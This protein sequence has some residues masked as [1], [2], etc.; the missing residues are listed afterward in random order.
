[1]SMI[2]FSENKKH[3]QTKIFFCWHYIV[4]NYF[5]TSAIISLLWFLLATIITV[6]I[7]C[8]DCLSQLVMS[9][10][11]SLVN[12]V[13][14][15]TVGLSFRQRQNA[16]WFYSL[17]VRFGHVSQSSTAAPTAGII[18]SHRPPDTISPVL[19][20]SVT[21]WRFTG[22]RPVGITQ[23][24]FI[25]LMYPTCLRSLWEWDRERVTRFKRFIVL[26]VNRQSDE[27]RCTLTL[28]DYSLLTINFFFII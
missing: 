4:Q 10:C 26:S 22:T 11:S 9:F 16:V 18:Y 6:K 24:H 17:P 15:Q 13:I 5:I 1:M 2:H 25:F 3:N 20:S 19:T 14:V 28:G 7:W 12:R 27:W 8:C 21:S 23:H